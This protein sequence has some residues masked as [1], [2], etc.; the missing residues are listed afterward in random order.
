M[1]KL[2]L[3]LFLSSIFLTQAAHGFDFHEKE[4]ETEESLWKLYER[5][6]SHHSVPRSLHEREKRFNVFRY[7][8][9]HVHNSN[10]KNKPYKLKLN[11]FAD[12]T[13]HEFVNAYAGSNV[14]HHRMFHGPKLGSGRFMYENVTKTPVSVDWRAEGAVTE[15]KNQGQCESCWAFSTVAA[16]EGI[17]QIKT[18]KLVS[19]SEQELVDCDTY[20]N[21][22]CNGG[23]M[24]IA[25]EFIKRNGG[26]T[27]E[28]NY[29]YEAADGRCDASKGVFTGYCGTELNHGVAAVGYGVDPDGTKFWI[30]KNSWG[31]EWGEGGYIRMERGISDSEGKCGIAMEA[32]YPVKLSS[33]NP[34]ASD[35]GIKDEL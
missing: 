16:V 24:E 5:W 13:L 4:L 14:K 12:L 11:K 35:D 20:Q 29:P 32:S 8:V 2:V 23:L 6:R 15:V 28:E 34:D 19:L 22:G 10:K 21:Q 31:P 27:T 3:I 30:V 9:M 26:I 7:N 33:S 1:K 17:N 25:F 18:K